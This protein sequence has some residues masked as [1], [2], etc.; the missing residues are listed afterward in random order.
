MHKTAKSVRKAGNEARKAASSAKMDMSPI[1]VEDANMLGIILAQLFLKQGMKEWGKERA[2]E[3][4]MK[5]FQMLHDL[6][7]FIPRDPIILTREG[8]SR[9]LST[10]VFMKEKRDGRLKTRSSMNGAPQREYI[11][12]EDAAAPRVATDSVFIAETISA[13]EERNNMLFDI[14]GA[15]VTTKTDKYIIMTLRGSL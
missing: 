6:N 15:F 12:K 4:I 7:Y 8:R 11:K 13:H 14:P 9:A 1:E 2:D 10:I 3:S 5:E